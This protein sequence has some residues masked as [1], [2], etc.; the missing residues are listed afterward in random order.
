M[1]LNVQYPMFN[2]QYS[3]NETIDLKGGGVKAGTL[4]KILVQQGGLAGKTGLRF[5]MRTVAAQPSTLTLNLEPSTF[6]LQRSILNV[7]FS[8][9]DVQF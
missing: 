1:L 6:N 3:I 9:F 5:G 7:Q 4:Y 2:F 8:I